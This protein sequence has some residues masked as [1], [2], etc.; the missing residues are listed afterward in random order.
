MTSYESVVETK[1]GVAFPVYFLMWNKGADGVTTVQVM[2]DGELNTEKI[3]AINGGD[4]RV[5]ELQ[6]TID[7]PGEHTVSVGGMTKTIN[8]TECSLFPSAPAL[9][10]RRVFRSVLNFPTSCVG[11]SIVISRFI[12]Y[13]AFQK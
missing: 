1:A 4:W 7:Q 12:P 13:N 6:M 8:I 3:M 5:V 10:G 2:V 9:R 11:Y